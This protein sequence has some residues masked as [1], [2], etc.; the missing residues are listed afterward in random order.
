MRRVDSGTPEALGLTLVDGGANFA[1]ASAHATAVD[2]CLFGNAGITEVERIRLP[3]R[4]GDVF[5]GFVAD[6][7]PGMRYGLRVHGPWE[8]AQG[9]VFNPAKLLVDP[10]ARAL[11]RAFAYCPLQCAR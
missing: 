4:T 9:H 11:D 10:Y 8:P 1:V 3:E 7:G 6:I 2:L 5:H